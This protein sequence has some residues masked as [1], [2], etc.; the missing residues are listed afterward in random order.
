MNSASLCSLAGRYDNP[1]PPRFL[2]PIDCLKIPTPISLGGTW[3]L[4]APQTISCVIKQTSKALFFSTQ[5]IVHEYWLK[6]ERKELRELR[7]E[8]E[9][10]PEMQCG[11]KE[12]RHCVFACFVYFLLSKLC[13]TAMGVNPTRYP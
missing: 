6:T 11:K 3:F 13:D 2:A 8:R 7:I 1:I 10:D 5:Q 4:H 9:K 12:C